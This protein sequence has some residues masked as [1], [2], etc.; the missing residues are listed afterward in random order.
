MGLKAHK[1][2]WRVVVEPLSVNVGAVLA[3]HCGR[4]LLEL[5]LVVKPSESF[6]YAVISSKG[7]GGREES[8]TSAH[9]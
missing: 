6:L 9:T 8:P 2:V 5:M 3:A 4:C 7:R 1:T